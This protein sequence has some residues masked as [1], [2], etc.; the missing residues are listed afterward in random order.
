MAKL[1]IEPQTARLY[2]DTEMFSKMDPFIKFEC[3]GQKKK[4][5]THHS[6][7]KNPTWDDCITMDAFGCKNLIITVYDEDVF[8]NDKIGTYSIPISTIQ[9]HGVFKDWVKLMYKGK[10]AGELYL[11]ITYMDSKPAPHTFGSTSAMYASSPAM[12]APSPA[13]YSPPPAMY[14]PPPAMYSP[15]PAMYSPPPAMYASSPAPAMY[16]PAPAATYLPPSTAPTYYPPTRAGVMTTNPPSFPTAAGYSHKYAPS[17]PVYT[18][19]PA[20]YNASSSTSYPQDESLSADYCPV[21]TG[22]SP[23]TAGPYSTT[24]IPAEPMPQP[25]T[26][27]GYPSAI[28]TMYK[29]S[30]SY[31][32]YHPQ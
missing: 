11:E 27:Y 30:P 5:K 6:G 3:G 16:A 29:P 24:P 18:H 26:T 15:P 9:A 4:T 17:A 19:S 10:I 23:S 8:S 31:Y 22:P 14:S 32:A 1:I 2:R 25:P 28:P 21:A 7:G 12:Y 13:L 20:A